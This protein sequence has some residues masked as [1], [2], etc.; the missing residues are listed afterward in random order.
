MTGPLPKAYMKVRDE[1]MHSLG[2]G[3]TH[4][5]KSVV[6]GVFVPVWR[7]AGLHACGRRSPSGAA[8]R[9]PSAS[10]GTTSRTPTYD[11]KVTELEVPVYF[12]SGRFDYTVNHDLAKAYLEQLKAPVKG[13]YTFEQSA[14]SPLFE[15]PARMRRDP[16]GGRPG[17]SDQARGQDDQPGRPEADQRRRR[18][19]SRR[20]AAR[21]PCATVTSA[22]ARS[23]GR[24]SPT[25]RA[26]PAASS[27][28]M[29]FRSSP[30][31]TTR[32]AH[33]EVPGDEP[34]ALTLVGPARQHHD[35]TR[36][37]VLDAEPGPAGAGE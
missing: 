31:A 28:V 21:S 26:W 17:R 18:N 30:Q 2:V 6:T 23:A 5:M 15:E 37:H 1:A 32:P 19:T 10:C 20:A 33:A 4:D 12:C 3:T 14:H 11:Q 24:A 29:S 35:H 9:S 13:F 22:T 27:S 8:R 7:D 36:A 16:R 25:A 34:Q